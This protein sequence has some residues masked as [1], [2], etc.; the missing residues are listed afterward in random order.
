MYLL[1]HN[2]AESLHCSTHHIAFWWMYYNLLLPQY[3]FGPMVCLVKMITAWP[4]LWI[5]SQNREIHAT[6]INERTLDPMNEHIT[7]IDS[8][9]ICWDVFIK[10]Q[11]AILRTTIIVCQIHWPP[12]A[13]NKLNSQVWWYNM[14]Q[15]T[16]IGK[17]LPR[18]CLHFA[19][20][21]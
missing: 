21:Q 18:Q 14:L 16:S 10:C 13:S 15:A 8:T 20:R 2:S 7:K 3:I 19:V 6:T 1:T 17:H 9:N 4:H 12:S 11:Q 5:S